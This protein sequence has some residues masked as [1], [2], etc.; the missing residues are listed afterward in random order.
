MLQFLK[1]ISKTKLSPHGVL[2]ININHHE[3]L[4]RDFD[5]VR[6]AFPASSIW[7]VPETGNYVALG[8]K[9][10][11]Q[12]STKEILNAADDYT[13]QQES[14]FNYRWSMERVLEAMRPQIKP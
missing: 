4:K 14:P 8:F 5:S 11:I 10:P 9:S 2:A 6:A 12:Q 13:K 1:N 7:Q 3:G